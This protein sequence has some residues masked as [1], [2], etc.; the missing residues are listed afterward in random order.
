R[1]F[2]AIAGS[3]SGGQLDLPV[4]RKS[5]V[6]A[7]ALEQRLDRGAQAQLVQRGR[8][9]LR[10]DR[11]EALDLE[12]DALDGIAHRLGGQRGVLLAQ[13]G[14]QQQP[15]SAETLERLVVQLA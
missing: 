6:L 8:A 10:D 13:R 12:L 2:E 9:Q 1:L 14:R 5:G 15:Q 11:A 7:L 3:R 4:D